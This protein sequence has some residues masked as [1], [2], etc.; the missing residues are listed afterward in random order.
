MTLREKRQQQAEASLRRM[1]AK[2][3][4]LLADLV[5]VQNTIRELH[6]RTYAERHR[7]WAMPDGENV[8]GQGWPHP[9]IYPA[10][11]SAGL[12]QGATR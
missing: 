9:I 3:E 10:A 12:H 7:L 8:T 2:R 6:N 11:L 5:R 1:L 4:K